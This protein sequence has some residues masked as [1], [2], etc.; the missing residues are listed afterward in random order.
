MC[1][2]KV[3]GAQRGYKHT[4]RP[5]PVSFQAHSRR[6]PMHRLVLK[7]ALLT[8][9]AAVPRFLAAQQPARADTTRDT[10][11]VTELPELNV[12]VARTTEPLSRVPFA[13]A[14]LDRAALQRGQQTVGI[15]EA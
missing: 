8:V 7:L 11:R 10:T 15:D 6:A 9:I 12:T 4:A 1:G 13:T 5:G 3:G 2:R 14:V